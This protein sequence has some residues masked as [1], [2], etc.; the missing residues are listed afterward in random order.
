[1]ADAIEAI[2]LPQVR[3]PLNFLEAAVHARLLREFER[4]ATAE[5]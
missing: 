4:Q 5:C 2:A 1:M 3:G